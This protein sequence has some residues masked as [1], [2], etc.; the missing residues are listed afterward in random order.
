MVI[1]NENT[2]MFSE[3]V[4][5]VVGLMKVQNN[6][7]ITENRISK[8]TIDISKTTMLFSITLLTS[9]IAIHGS[10]ARFEVPNY[11]EDFD[12]SGKL[13]DLSSSNF[14]LP[15]RWNWYGNG[16]NSGGLVANIRRES[17]GQC[18]FFSTAELIEAQMQLSG[19]FPSS[20]NRISMS[21]WYTCQSTTNAGRSLRD[22][23]N[24]GLWYD[25]DSNSS[26][27]SL[28]SDRNKSKLA[29]WP[30]MSLLG[31]SESANKILDR[32]LHKRDTSD[33]PCKFKDESFGTNC[34]IY[35]YGINAKWSSKD[36]NLKQLTTSKYG[37]PQVQAQCQAFY[38]TLRRSDSSLNPFKCNDM[39]QDGEF[40]IPPNN[41]IKNV[42][43]RHGF[44][45]SVGNAT[46]DPISRQA[47]GILA[48]GPTH[49]IVRG[50]ALQ[51]SPPEHPSGSYTNLNH[52][53]NVV[54]W[55]LAPTDPKVVPYWIIQNSWSEAR[56][57]DGFFFLP[58]QSQ[59]A[60][61]LRQF[62]DLFFFQRYEGAKTDLRT[63]IDCNPVPF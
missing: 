56:G 13:T 46:L 58:I 47:Y 32:K 4:P 16:A 19:A 26:P 44:P 62:T 43:R 52:Q 38:K 51:G 17:G 14:K 50:A 60:A 55:D 57:Q 25:V 6:F 54:G 40:R 49:M 11:F 21:P 22:S 20:I 10:H 36:C 27:G 30:E 61:T 42:C 8:I 29:I 39:K 53:V 59:D 31:S 12:Y 37:S 41:G 63:H 15:L 5:H 18:V 28:I 35:Q 33:D 23:I 34:D 3:K 45:S 7:K 2:M 48:Y 9:C 1:A 24:M